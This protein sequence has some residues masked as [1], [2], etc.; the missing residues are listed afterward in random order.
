[1]DTRLASLA[2]LCSGYEGGY[3]GEAALATDHLL[4]TKS[5]EIE[6]LL[7]A[8][9]DVHQALRAAAG[10]AGGA[11]AHTLARHRDILRDLTQEHQRLQALA[12]AARDRADLLG[13]AGPVPGGAGTDRSGMGLLLRE[14][15]ALASSTSAVDDVIGAAQAVAGALHQQRTTFEGIGGKLAAVGGRFPAVNALL[16][17]V[18]R[19]KNKDNVILASVVAV[20]MLLILLYWARK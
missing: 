5:G 12:G 13:G 7:T 20:C 11:R 15:G 2:K 8:L 4:R 16:N 6:R 9:A 18:R 19:K 17:A 1:M 10:G 14:R 3:S